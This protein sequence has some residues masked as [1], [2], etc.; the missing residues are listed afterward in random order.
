MVCHVPSCAKTDIKVTTKIT[1]PK[2]FRYC[3]VRVVVCVREPGPVAEVNIRNAAPKRVD[4]CLVP[5][6]LF[7]FTHKLS[8][9]V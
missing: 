7:S 1:N 8:A 2:E 3:S 6:M 5:K 4:Y 9:P